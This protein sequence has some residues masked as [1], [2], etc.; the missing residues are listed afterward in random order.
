[1][2][3]QLHVI[4]GANQGQRFA[5]PLQGAVT[6]GRSQ[7]HAD[8]ILHD[9]Y[10]ARVHCEVEV[11]DDGVLVRALP[12]AASGL[13]VNGATVKEA[14]VRPAQ[15]FR[16]GNSHLRLEAFDHAHPHADPDAADEVVEAEEEVIEA[17]AVEGD[18]QGDDDEVA[19]PAGP[20]QL[21]HVPLGRLKVLSGQTVSH[22]RLGEVLGRGHYGVVFHARHVNSGSEVALKV[23][24]PE[25]P[26]GAVE[27]RTFVAALKAIL[28][29]RHPNLVTLY[30]AGRTGPY[31][32]LALEHVAG[33]SLA[34]RLRE[35]DPGRSHWKSAL[36][37]GVHLGRALEFLRK[38]RL[39]HGNI[40][41]A[42]V[43]LGCD[44]EGRTREVKLGDLMLSRALKGS[45][46]ARAHRQAKLEAEIGYMAPEQL[47]EGAAVDRLTDLYGL[48]AVMYARLT[49]GPPFEG[50]DP[51]DTRKRILKAGARKPTDF[52]PNIPEP[53]SR[54]VMRL[55]ARRPEDRYPSPADLLADLEEL[56]DDEG[57]EV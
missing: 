32:W 23:L 57:V 8:I 30:N 47:I 55:L 52:H 48:G 17:V 42:N 40:A 41:P 27:M 50:E 19:V 2:G 4:D 13:I 24:S 21:P 46:L 34:D 26:Q 18:D 54:A 12:D 7:R 5:L 6:I 33:D 36:R 31:C 51:A 44:G 43:L 35:D 1:M 11:G 56:A 9:L 22:Y 14:L 38:H 15:V 25:F 49:G 53:L 20:G 3:W 28:G 16:L 37:I 45:S 10:V 39:V 29:K